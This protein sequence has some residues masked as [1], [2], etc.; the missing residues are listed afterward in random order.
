MSITTFGRRVTRFEHDNAIKQ[1]PT[2]MDNSWNAICIEVA[3]AGHKPHFL[4]IR[5]HRPKSEKQTNFMPNVVALTILLN[6]LRESNVTYPEIAFFPLGSRITDKDPT[7]L[8]VLNILRGEP[9]KEIAFGNLEDIDELFFDKSL[10]IVNN[11]ISARMKEILDRRDKNHN[12]VGQREIFYRMDVS[13]E[14]LDLG[15]A[16]SLARV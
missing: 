4:R 12:V 14:G 7:I 6:K 1:N 8:P 16:K 10:S 13:L 5:A 3:E 15:I 2:T 11:S 9:E